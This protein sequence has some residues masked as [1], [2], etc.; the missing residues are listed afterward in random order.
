VQVDTA[1]P[2]QKIYALLSSDDPSRFGDERICAATAGKTVQQNNL[3]DGRSAGRSSPGCNINDTAQLP[4][5]LN[6]IRLSKL[7]NAA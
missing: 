7:R 4:N 5:Y 6:P 2:G 1:L 3:V